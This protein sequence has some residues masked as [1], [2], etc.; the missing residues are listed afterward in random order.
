VTA[1]PSSRVVL[2]TGAAKR[3]GRELALTLARAGWQVAVH[4]R[5]SA[6]DAAELVAQLCDMGCPAQA[7]EADL[8]NAAHVSALVPAVAAA[9][10]RIDAVVNNA[11]L[12]E[13]DAA[14][15]FTPENALKQYMA[16]TLAPAMLARDLH[17]HLAPDAAGCVINLLDQKLWNMNPDFFTYTLSKAALESATT[18][19]AQALAGV[20][21]G[22]W[23]HAGERRHEQR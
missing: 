18:M 14:A 9:F 4:Y 19:L 20:R 10:G 23:R 12:F 15:S 3:I 2:I 5:S 21:R 17:A 13:N 16:N 22:A 1:K 8:N 7:F 6:A 11:S